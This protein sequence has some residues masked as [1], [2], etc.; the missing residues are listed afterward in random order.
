MTRVLQLVVDQEYRRKGI[1]S[2]LLRSIWGFS[3]DF[4][5]GLASA[6]PCTVKT[7]E[8]ATFRK[9]STEYISNNLDAV[10]LIGAD[11]TFVD[12]DA[13]KVDKNTAQVDTHF[14]ADNTDYSRNVDCSR[15]LGELQ[16]GHEW[17]AFTFREQPILR[18]KFHQH[19][20][21]MMR[22]Y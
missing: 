12:A 9:C 8:S 2:T 4:A 17:L 18:E 16:P 1:A 19:F 22:G 21:R 5:W 14:F 11:T 7:L 13:Y 10:K 3:D 15:Y 20:T 6:N